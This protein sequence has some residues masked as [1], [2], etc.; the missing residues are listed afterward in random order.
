MAGSAPR[1][2]YDD[3]GLQI[4]IWSRVFI[5]RWPRAVVM[6]SGALRDDYLARGLDPLRDLLA[7]RGREVLELGR[8]TVEGILR[9]E[10]YGIVAGHVG[11]LCVSGDG[12]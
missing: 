10:R 4:A 7:T 3:E 11:L 8:Q 6:V 5:N 1:V 2:V 9:Q 12:A